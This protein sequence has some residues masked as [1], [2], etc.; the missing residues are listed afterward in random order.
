MNTICYYPG[1]GVADQAR[2]ME[3]AARASLAV[4]G[5]DMQEM[6]RWNCCGTVY[7]LASDDLMRHVGPA[8]VLARARHAGHDKLLTLCSMCYSTLKRSELFLTEDA[9]RLER[10]NTYLDDEPDYEGGLHVVHMLEFLRDVIGYETVEAKVVRPLERLTV[11]PYY[12]CT[13]TRPRAAGIDDPER[14]TVMEDLL[15]ALGAEPVSTPQ[16]IECCG[17]YLTASAPD[18]ARRRVVEIERAAA[19]RGADLI[20]TSCPL[21]QYNLDTRLAEAG[22]TVGQRVPSVYFT[23]LMALALGEDPALEEEQAIHPLPALQARGLS[24]EVKA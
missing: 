24:V 19:A 22:A 18:V 16:R 2:R 14:P 12:G 10:V 4:L 9:E 8:R 13:L 15:S 21:C 6:E 17:S 5:W 1:C 3:S 11:A 23:Q 7:S 20:A